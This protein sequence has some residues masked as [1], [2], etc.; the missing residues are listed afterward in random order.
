MKSINSE[1]GAAAQQYTRAARQDIRKR[2]L[3]YNKPLG[4][5]ACVDDL[6]KLE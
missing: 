2:N 6:K 5:I 1:S 4:V 3:D